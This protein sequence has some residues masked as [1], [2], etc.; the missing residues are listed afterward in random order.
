MRAAISSQSR[1]DAIEIDLD[2]HGR[3]IAKLASVLVRHNVG[4]GRDLNQEGDALERRRSELKG[5]GV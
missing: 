4:R 5:A 1:Q 2:A 3:E